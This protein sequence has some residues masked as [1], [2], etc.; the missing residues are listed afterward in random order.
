MVDML[1]KAAQSDSHENPGKHSITI[2]AAMMRKWSDSMDAQ[3]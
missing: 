3:L 1:L 2:R